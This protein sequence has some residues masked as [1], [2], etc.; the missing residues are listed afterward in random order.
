MTQDPEI[1]AHKQ[2]LGYVQPVGLV[3]SPIALAAAQA[4]PEKNIIPE[5][6]RF[7][8]CVEPLTI[9]GQTDPLPAIREF[10]R[11]AT[12]VLSGSS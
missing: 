11:F 4:Y 5:H 10:P 8:D 7:L 6:A 2:W 1:Y 9:D 3:V 12:A